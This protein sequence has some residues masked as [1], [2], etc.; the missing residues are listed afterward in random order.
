[1]ERIGTLLLVSVVCAGVLASDPAGHASVQKLP[2]L[3]AF[4]EPVHAIQ[5]LEFVDLET[6]RTPGRL[7]RSLSRLEATQRKL[8]PALWRLRL[9]RTEARYLAWQRQFWDPR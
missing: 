4:L 1:M 8:D 3:G 7:R 9:L 2:G 5:T 6:A